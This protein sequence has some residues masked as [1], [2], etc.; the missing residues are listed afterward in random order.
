MK[1]D[2]FE[3][4]GHEFK[5]PITIERYQKNKDD[6]IDLLNNGQNYVIQEL[7]FYG[8]EGVS[9]MNLMVLTVKLKLLFILCLIIRILLLRID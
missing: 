5:Y 9:I 6:D 1:I 7:K 2:K 3:I 4:K 8:L